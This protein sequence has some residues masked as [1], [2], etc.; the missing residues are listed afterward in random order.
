MDT[1]E[2]RMLHAFEMKLRHD[3]QQ[4]RQS[5]YSYPPHNN[6]GR[7]WPKGKITKPGRMA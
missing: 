2:K 4:A 1:M 6:A 5:D 7:I 3:K